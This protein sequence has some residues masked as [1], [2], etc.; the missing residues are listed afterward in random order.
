MLMGNVSI[1]NIG[2]IT[3]LKIP[4]ISATIKAVWKDATSTPGTYWEIIKIA[5][6]LRI[7]LASVEN[8]F[9]NILYNLL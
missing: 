5:S 8:G 9:I 4:K 6:A 3:A 7:Q 2:L 1:I